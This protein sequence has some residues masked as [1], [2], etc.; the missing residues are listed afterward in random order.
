MSNR[1][2]ETYKE[3]NALLRKRIYELKKTLEFP[4]LE[5]MSRDMLIEKAESLDTLPFKSTYLAK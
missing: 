2:K 5:T 4:R 1:S 3:E